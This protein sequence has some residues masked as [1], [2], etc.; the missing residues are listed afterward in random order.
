MTRIK[1]RMAKGAAWMVSL[2]FVIRSMGLVSTIILAR[3]L[4]PT[5]FGLIALGTAMIAVVEIFSSFNF[6]VAL[7]Q[8]Q[9]AKRSHYDTA[10]T[11]NLILAVVTGVVLALLATPTAEF[12][13]EPRL[14][15]VIYFLAVGVVITGIGNVGIVDFRKNLEFHREFRFM[16]SQKIVS[17]VV[18][19]PL[20]FIFRNYWALVAG[21]LA[22]R[23]A[24]TGASYIMH[25]YRPRIALSAW[26]ELFH[27]SKWL[28][29]N[30][31]IYVLRHR[32]AD[33][34]IAKIA[35]ARQLGVFTLSYEIS[36]LATT[37]LAAPIDR[38]ILPGYAR[39]STNLEALRDGYF[40]V[41]GMIAL[42]GVPAAIGIAA[43]AELF[44]PVL[45]G[46]NW[47]ET[48]EVIQILAVAGSIS[49]LATSI[50]SICIA[51]GKPKYLIPLGGVY[52]IILLP[53]LLILTPRFHG[54]GA[55]WA[56]LGAAAISL[57]V[58]LFIVLNLLDA[59]V[60]QLIA[61]LWRPLVT[62]AI[63]FLVLK[64]VMGEIQ[65]SA[66]LVGQA[67]QL[68]AIVG[69]GVTAYVVLVFV[70]WRLAGSPAGAETAV[71]ERI[72]DLR[73][74]GAARNQ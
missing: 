11:L 42:I 18:V 55:A 54:L 39:M 25:P 33:F 38:A 27:F 7:I 36:S 66:A 2:K 71:A 52:V 8:N 46:P 6:E 37:E 56:Y 23:I 28:L 72:G 29:L 35:G 20:A 63:M 53:L 59:N 30:N 70:S 50:G 26:R 13:D 32:S 15:I 73:K 41:I 16:L 60:R 40:S 69:M 51:A 9:E 45:L 57:P 43:T 19:V 48:I 68:A 65:T 62:S 5:D 58:Q 3:L 34:I 1:L 22:G 61:V 74:G 67:L 4:L 21:I 44:V 31:A 24:G 12:Y 10:W 47:L 49:I 17:F 64:V 14:A